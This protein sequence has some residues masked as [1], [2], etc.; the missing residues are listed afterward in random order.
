MIGKNFIKALP[1]GENGAIDESLLWK[2]FRLRKG[3]LWHKYFDMWFQFMMGEIDLDELYNV[4]EIMG[5]EL[6]IPSENNSLGETKN[7]S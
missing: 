2:Q 4:Y 1:D 3:T 6:T 5:L 7:E